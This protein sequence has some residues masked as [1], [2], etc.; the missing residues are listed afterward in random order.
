[1]RVLLL[2]RETVADLQICQLSPLESRDLW[3]GPYLKHVGIVAAPEI[4]PV[5][6]EG[7]Y[8]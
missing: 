6:Q 5:E 1:M 8:V 3:T 2:K 4:G 7:I